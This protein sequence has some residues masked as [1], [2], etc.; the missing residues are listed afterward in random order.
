[1]NK[2]YLLGNVGQEP[3]SKPTMNGYVLK[4]SL[5]VTEFSKGEK[6]TTWLRVTC[7]GK[8]ADNMAKMLHK[9]SKVL[10]E[11]R[12]N[13]HNTED[14]YGKKLS[15]TNIVANN[16]QVLSPP[17]NK[18]EQTNFNTQEYTTDDIPF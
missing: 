14:A 10:V 1:M 17:K 9:G 3:E 8:L 15:Y 5:G 18:T 2:C 12:I 16:I 7:F 4:F 11:G 13:I 6:T